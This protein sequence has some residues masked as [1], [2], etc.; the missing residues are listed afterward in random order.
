MLEARLAEITAMWP[1]HIV[2]LGAPVDRLRLEKCFAGVA[3]CP[4]Y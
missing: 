1:D 2:A 3:T 4:P